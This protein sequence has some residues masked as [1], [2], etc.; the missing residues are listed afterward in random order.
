MSRDCSRPPAELREASPAGRRLGV[1]QIWQAAN[2]K[3]PTSVS[4][5]RPEPDGGPKPARDT[6]GFAPGEAGR[7]PSFLSGWRRTPVHL[8]STVRGGPDAPRQ[9]FPALPTRAV[10]SAGIDPASSG[11]PDRNELAPPL[12]QRLR[13]WSGSANKYILGEIVLGEIV[14]GEMVLGEVVAA[15][16][17]S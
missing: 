10:V 2:R 15:F 3:P 11:S 12:S 5:W 8:T 7:A 17:E 16:G 1:G 9:P 4:R 14:L 6:R 13:L